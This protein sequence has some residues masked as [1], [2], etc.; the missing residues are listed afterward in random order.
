MVISNFLADLA[1]D[2]FVFN[3]NF[4]AKWAIFQQEVLP[5]VGDARRVDPAA[6][7]NGASGGAGCVSEIKVQVE[8][9]VVPVLGAMNPVA[10]MAA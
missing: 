1:F 5:L 8:S 10:A 6:P 2:S 9:I 4:S 3:Y 7:D